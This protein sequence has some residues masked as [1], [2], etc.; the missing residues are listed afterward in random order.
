MDA[1]QR[2]MTLS[3]YDTPEAAAIRAAPVLG[4]GDYWRKIVKLSSPPMGG[5]IEAAQALTH[6]GQIDKALS[7]LE[8]ACTKRGY[9]VVYLGV[10][11]SLD[12]L[13]SDSRFR[14]LLRRVGIA[15]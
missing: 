6:L 8:Q 5:E 14:E 11:P 9:G 15:Q 12:L 3:G 7:L 1:Y 13:R 4:A 2:C 10:E